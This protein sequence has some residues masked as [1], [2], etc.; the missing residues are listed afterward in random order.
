MK[1]RFQACLRVI[2]PNLLI[3]VVCWP[4]A[5]VA[6][7]EVNLENAARVRISIAGDETQPVLRVSL[8][9]K[10]APEMEV[11]FPEHVTAKK[12]EES[13][14]EH[15]YLFR[16]GQK[17]EAP[18]WKRTG[19]SI[20]YERDFSD[21]IHM[22]ARATLQS[23]GLL[24]HYEFENRSDVDFA[25]ITAVTDPRMMGIFHDVRLERTY[26]HRKNGFGLLAAETPARLTMPLNEWL[27]ARYLDSF[28]WPVPAQLVER[29]ADGITY[30][31]A[32]R[33][34]D[35]PMIATVSSDGK[36]VAASFT[37]MTG[38]VW[39]N[40]ELTCQHVDPERPLPPHGKAEWDVKIL[41]FQGTLDQA[42]EKVRAQRASLQ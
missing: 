28:T 35:L 40:P 39:S 7:T 4:V 30:Y 3:A 23:D 14:A 36:W 29:R 11:L 12:K 42:L 41:I 26:V 33:P 22:L 6:Q 13:E 17:G 19:D 34:V 16:P 31:N 25:M 27:P 2:L 10:S 38:N 32:S 24:F 15:L 20:E 21:G 9:G 8:P 1:M 18:K 37:K 5:L